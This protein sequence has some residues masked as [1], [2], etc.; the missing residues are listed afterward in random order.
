MELIGE[1]LLELKDKRNAIRLPFGVSNRRNV[2]LNT[3]NDRN[4]CH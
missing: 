3:M 4:W 2:D 1:Q